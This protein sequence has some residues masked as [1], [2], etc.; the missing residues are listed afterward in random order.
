MKMTDERTFSEMGG[1]TDLLRTNGYFDRSPF[2]KEE[3][4]R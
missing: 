2:K 4:K 1:E 3:I